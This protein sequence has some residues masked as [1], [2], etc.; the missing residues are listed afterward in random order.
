M[1][2][3]WLSIRS[4]CWPGTT[5]AKSLGQ[6]DSAVK[7]DT[8]ERTEQ[9]QGGQGFNVMQPTLLDGRPGS[10]NEG[11]AGMAAIKDEVP[12][13]TK[14]VR[15]L[16]D[17]KKLKVQLERLLTEARDVH[18]EMEVAAER[19]KTLGPKARA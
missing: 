11:S 6:V 13:R 9:V 4:F 15:D 18:V 16:V 10:S 19:D 3:R 2:G 5:I 7:H 12:G 17:F 8:V 1:I 14:L